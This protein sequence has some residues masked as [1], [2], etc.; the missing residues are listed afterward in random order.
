MNFQ[1]IEAQNVEYL[2]SSFDIKETVFDLNEGS[3]EKSNSSEEKVQGE[4][5]SSEGIIL[6]ELPKHPKYVFLGLE[7]SKPVIIAADLTK[8]KK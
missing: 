3:T 4:E 5:K 1:Y 8:E 2:N 6:K 7:K